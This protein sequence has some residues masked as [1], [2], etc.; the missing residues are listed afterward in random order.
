M[1]EDC[2]QYIDDNVHMDQ[3]QG[4]DSELGTFVIE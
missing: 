2:E 3:D 1:E 4:S